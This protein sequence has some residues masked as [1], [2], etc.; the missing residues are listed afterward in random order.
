MLYVQC[1]V[2]KIYTQIFSFFKRVVKIAIL[3]MGPVSNENPGNF[4][5]Y[6]VIHE[7]LNPCIFVKITVFLNFML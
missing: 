1:A 6:R 7:F 2:G 4:T 3:G 5:F